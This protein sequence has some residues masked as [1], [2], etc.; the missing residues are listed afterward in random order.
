M[1]LQKR[2]AELEAEKE[3][4]ERKVVQADQAKV[5]SIKEIKQRLQTLE[6]EKADLSQKLHALEEEQKIEEDKKSESIDEKAKPSSK[7]AKRR[8]SYGVDCFIDLSEGSNAHAHC[9]SG[10][11][12]ISVILQV[13]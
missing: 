2:L 11:N 6:K 10:S 7:P 8:V 13:L 4:L 9:F 5:S 3:R 12:S 1:H